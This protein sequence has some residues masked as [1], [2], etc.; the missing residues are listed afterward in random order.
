M[1]NSKYTVIIESNRKI[2]LENVS[3]KI[4]MPYL[5]ISFVKRNALSI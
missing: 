2:L 3:S 1:L 4:E 5:T